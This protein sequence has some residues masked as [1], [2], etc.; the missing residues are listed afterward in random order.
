MNCN[1]VFVPKNAS[2]TDPFPVDLVIFSNV[3]YSILIISE[4]V[5]MLNNG[6]LYK[7]TE[8]IFES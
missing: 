7:C 3:V 6:D 2:T 8:Y 5:P 4:S 1:V